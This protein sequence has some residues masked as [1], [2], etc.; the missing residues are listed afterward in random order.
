M[1]HSSFT[2]YR[3]SLPCCL[4]LSLSRN[5]ATQCQGDTRQEGFD[6]WDGRQLLDSDSLHDKHAAQSGE[7]CPSGAAS[8][9]TCR[10]AK[11]LIPSMQILLRGASAQHWSLRIPAPIVLWQSH[12]RF[13]K[14]EVE[15]A[16]FQDLSYIRQRHYHKV[17]LRHVYLASCE[18]LRA[19]LSCKTNGGLLMDDVNRQKRKRT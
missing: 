18:S 12:F 13:G 3:H 4:V 19:S 10:R 15:C 17:S 14:R 9:Q 8:E 11:S 5:V 6:S 7:L 2:N 1:N 16:L